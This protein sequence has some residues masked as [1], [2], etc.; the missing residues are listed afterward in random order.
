MLN[1][2]T[3]AGRACHNGAGYVS[4]VGHSGTAGQTFGIVDIEH[5]LRF[6][7]YVTLLGGL[8]DSEHDLPPPRS[9]FK[10]RAFIS[11]VS[12]SFTHILIILLSLDSGRGIGYLSAP[13]SRRILC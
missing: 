2:Y 5:A 6:A 13:I 4:S 7:L 1:E 12:F 9:D 10:E 3:Q 8:A 11:T